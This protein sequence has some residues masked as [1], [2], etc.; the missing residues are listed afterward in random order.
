[1]KFKEQIVVQGVEEREDLLE[2]LEFV[3]FVLEN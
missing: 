3:E 1:M 2:D